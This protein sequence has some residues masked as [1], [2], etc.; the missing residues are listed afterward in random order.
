MD[1]GRLAAYNLDLRGVLTEA[2][3][4]VCQLLSYFSN[5]L[6]VFLAS[7]FDTFILFYIC[8]VN[9]DQIEKI[10]MIFKTYFTVY[11]LDFYLLLMYNVIIIA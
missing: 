2:S 3:Q 9:I 4:T 11:I 8:F 1:C 6:F 5:V 7:E 10:L